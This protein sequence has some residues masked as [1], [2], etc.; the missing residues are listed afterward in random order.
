[1]YDET[2][3]SRAEIEAA[4]AAAEREGKRVLIDFGADWCPDCHSLAAYLEG[5]RGRQLI[6]TSFVMVAVDVGYWDNN[7]DVAKEYGDA[8]WNGIPALVALDPDGT[9]VG[10][11][12][13]GSLASASRMS[14]TEVLD[15]IERWAP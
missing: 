6:D 7:L 10:S 14:E 4:L 8:I 15:Y 3:E 12:A 13:D 11:S 1:L 5:S 2:A 9:V